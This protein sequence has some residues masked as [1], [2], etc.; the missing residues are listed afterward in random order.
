MAGASPGLMQVILWSLVAGYL[1]GQLAHT[2]LCICSWFVQGPLHFLQM[3]LT[4]ALDQKFCF[5][6][7]SSP[8]SVPVLMFSLL[9]Y[10]I[11]VL[12]V[13]EATT[14]FSVL[15]SLSFGQQIIST[16]FCC[17]C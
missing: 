15:F 3:S 2:C 9:A 5:S 17:N 12:A 7:P 16:V 13:E 11:L 14:S 1:T 8:F 10:I 6:S 4:S